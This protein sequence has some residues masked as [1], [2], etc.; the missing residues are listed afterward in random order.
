MN[1]MKITPIRE[2]GGSRNGT[3]NLN[4]NDIVAIV[5]E[6]NVTDMDDEY[7]VKASWGFQDKSGRKGFIWSYHWYRPIAECNSF[8][9]DGNPE[10]M[11]E[12]FGENYE[13]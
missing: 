4:Y 11:K 12:L 9:A 6:P 10:L 1:K 3:V 2:T 5:G 13:N 7:K 8:S